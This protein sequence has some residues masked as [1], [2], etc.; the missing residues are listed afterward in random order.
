MKRKSE[1]LS[2]RDARTQ[3]AICRLRTYNRNTDDG[4][5][6]IEPDTITIARQSPGKSAESMTTLPRRDFDALVRW[7]LRPQA[8]RRERGRR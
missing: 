5:L 3:E 1:G 6:L 2:P 8:V 7:Y 4:W